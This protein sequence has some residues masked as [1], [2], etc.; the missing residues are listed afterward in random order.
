[1]FTTVDVINKNDLAPALEELSGSPHV[2]TG[3]VA[4]QEVTSC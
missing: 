3:A 1:M 2:I 4:R